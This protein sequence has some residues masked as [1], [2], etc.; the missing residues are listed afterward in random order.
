MKFLFM[1]SCLLIFSGPNIQELSGP[2]LRPT[3]ELS[4]PCPQISR[5]RGLGWVSQ[6]EEIGRDTPPN[7]PPSIAN[8]PACYRAPEP[9]TP[10]V[11]V[12]KSEKC[13]FGPPPPPK[14]WP[15][16]STKMSKK[17]VLGHQNSP[18]TDLLDIFIESR[19]HFSWGPKWHFFGL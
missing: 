14:K 8:A 15:Q 16:K 19:G 1:S 2:V 9:E 13:H 10:R 11:H 5:Y 6:Y 17:P 12:L 18:K 3:A 4:Q 7:I